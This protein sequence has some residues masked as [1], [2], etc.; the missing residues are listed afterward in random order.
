MS[1]LK[2]ELH[3]KGQFTKIELF[4]TGK[5]CPNINS[6]STERHMIKFK[7]ISLMISIMIVEILFA[8]S[9]SPIAALQHFTPVNPT[10]NPQAVVIQ[11]A[12]I[13]FVQIINGD[14]IGVFDENLCVGAGVFEETFPVVISAW[15]EAILP[16]TTLPGGRSGY[17][18]VFKVWKQS[19]D[20]ELSAIPTYTTGSGNFCEPLTVVTLL[21]AF[22]SQPP[23]AN[24]DGPYLGVVDVPVLFD[25]SSSYDPD[26]TIVSYEWDFGDDS[27]GTGVNPI[28][29]YAYYGTYQVILTVIDDDSLADSDTTTVEIGIPPDADANGPYGGVVGQPVEFD[30][31]GSVDSDGVI[32][33]YQWDFGDDSTGAGV[34]PTHIYSDYGTYQVLLTVIDDDSLTNSDTTTVEIGIPPDADANGPYRGVVSQPVEFNASGSVDSDGAIISYQWDFGDDST[35][36]G[37]YPTHVY[38]ICDTFNIILTVMDDDTLTDHDTTA[39]IILCP[40][41]AI[42]TLP[43][44]CLI[45]EKVIFDGS[46]SYDLD[47]TIDSYYWDFG[48]DSNAAGETL[49]QPEHI[50]EIPIVRI[51]RTI[52]II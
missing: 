16:D 8:S 24:A 21:E 4:N 30:G 43:D 25:G 50:Y 2:Q 14:E 11:D 19:M 47:G 52:K 1:L 48:D 44:T 13:D 32:I 12:T 38:S 45:N 35:G 17:P 26:G 36:T 10:G 41:K 9:F 20:T 28:H 51:N 6:I 46:G 49:T 5:H 31:S 39:A 3:K 27:T 18:M 34:Y 37:V 22:M 40:P 33:S 42:V 23:E 29:S 7:R 15:K